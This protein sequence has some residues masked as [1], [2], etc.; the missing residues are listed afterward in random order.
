MG[1]IMSS[2]EVFTG[3]TRLQLEMMEILSGMRLRFRNEADNGT[4]VSPY[5]TATLPRERSHLGAEGL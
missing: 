2:E 4:E 1:W 5:L 3:S